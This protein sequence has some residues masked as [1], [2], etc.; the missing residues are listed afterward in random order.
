ML[1]KSFYSLSLTLMNTVRTYLPLGFL[2]S[3]IVSLFFYETAKAWLSI[4]MFGLLG[5]A[6]FLYTP[7]TVITAYYKQKAMFVMSLSCLFLFLYLPFSANT[8]YALN[9]IEI[10]M[11]LFGLAIAFA[12]IGKIEQRR[13]H[14]ILAL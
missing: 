5:C 7:K 3:F 1:S 8:A 13:Y 11:P 2:C 6:V 12:V 14:F 4:S 9:R 10:K